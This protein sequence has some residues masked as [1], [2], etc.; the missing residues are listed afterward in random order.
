[1]RKTRTN[2]IAPK[3]GLQ[4]GASIK[5]GGRKAWELGIIIDYSSASRTYKVRTASGL[6]P[7]EVPRLIRDPGDMSIIPR[8]TTVVLHDE[9]GFLVIDS[10]LPQAPSQPVELAPT[11][12]TEIRGIGGEDPIY[13][14]DEDAAKFRQPNEPQDLLAGDRVIASKDGNLVAVLAGGTN[15]IKSSPLAQIRTHSLT[16]MVEIISNVYRHISALGDLKITNV[17]GRTS[18][19]W[20]AGSNQLTENGAGEEN[21]TIRLDAGATGD[22]FNLEITTP[23]GNTLSKIHM[24]ADGKTRSNRSKRYRFNH[25]SE[26]LTS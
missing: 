15:V 9:L 19:I 20:R 8:D 14:S 7:N 17:N 26:W 1:M 23:D 21:W 22:L 3:P 6:L 4:F 12:V 18:L 16:D 5:A 11:R 24:S 25:W 2:E 13:Q 10:I